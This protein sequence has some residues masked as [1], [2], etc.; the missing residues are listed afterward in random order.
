MKKKRGGEESEQE[1]I[2]WRKEERQQREAFLDM[3]TENEKRICFTLYVVLIL[4]FL[5]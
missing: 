3:E 1:L 2:W 4:C 5:T